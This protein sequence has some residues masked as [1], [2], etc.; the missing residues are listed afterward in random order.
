M[1][2]LA[3]ANTSEDLSVG[4]YPD[5]WLSHVKGR[6]RGT[7]YRGYESLVASTPSPT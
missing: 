4:K 5:Q 7:T 2:G 3:A 1:A 6:V